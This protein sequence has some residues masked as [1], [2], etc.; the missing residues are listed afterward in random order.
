MSKLAHSNEETMQ[1]IEWNAMMEDGISKD[2]AF[3]ILHAAGVD[4]ITWN[5]ALDDEYTHWVYVNIK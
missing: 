5:R 2:E 3:E 4:E 1:Q